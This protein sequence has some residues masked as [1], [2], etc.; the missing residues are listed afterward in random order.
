M[1]WLLKLMEHGRKTIPPP[2]KEGKTYMNF[3]R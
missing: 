1:A 3:I 2:E